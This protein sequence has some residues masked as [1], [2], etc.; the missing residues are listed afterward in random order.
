MTYQELNILFSSEKSKNPNLTKS[1][2]ISNLKKVEKVLSKDNFKKFQNDLIV[3]LHDQKTINVAISNNEYKFQ[4]GGSNN[5]APSNIKTINGEITSKN[6]I[7]KNNEEET[8]DENE[9]Q[10]PNKEMKPS[11]NEQ[12]KSTK[13][14][15]KLWGGDFDDFLDTDILFDDENILF[16]DTFDDKTYLF[17]EDDNDEES[18]IENA[19]NLKD[20]KYLSTLNVNELRNIMKEKNLQLSKKGTYLKKKEMIQ[21]ISKNS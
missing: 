6:D 16:N 10:Q 4:E 11:N 9:Q 13:P 5:F 21:K 12:Q 7:T 18:I 3:H 19:M 2:I 20:K 8:N 14:W 17:D 1:K 15:W